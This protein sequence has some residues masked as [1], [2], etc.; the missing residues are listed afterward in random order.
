MTA[1]TKLRIANATKQLVVFQPFN[2]ISVTTIMTQAKLRRQTFYDYFRDKYDVLDWIYT[3]EINEAV[4][5]CNT[6]KYWPQ[7]LLKMMTYFEKN[8]AF[9]RKVIEIDVQNAPE[10]VIAVHIQQ[11]VGNIFIDLSQ[12]EQLPIDNEYCH[13]LQGLLSRTLLL[14]LKRFLE[15]GSNLSLH[16]EVANLRHYLDDGINGLLL[17]TRRITAYHK[18]HDLK[19]ANQA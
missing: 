1:T 8:R 16:Q 13:F 15:D 14:E 19:S 9:Y 12:K 11:M 17:R 18:S 3:T 5:Y 4:K 6:Y 2:K 10:H 7:T